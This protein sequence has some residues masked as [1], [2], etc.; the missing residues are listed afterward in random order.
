MKQ[1]TKT[2]IRYSATIFVVLSL[3]ALGVTLLLEAKFSLLSQ[4]LPME[5]AETMMIESAP[6]PERMMAQSLSADDTVATDSVAESR[7]AP[8]AFAPPTAALKEEESPTL[9]SRVA[10]L[11][12]GTLTVVVAGVIALLSAALGWL[13]SLPVRRAMRMQ[14]CFVADISHELKTPLSLMSSELALFR[15]RYAHSSPS[16]EAVDTLV[17][18]LASDTARL[19]RLTNRLLGTMTAR[20]GSGAAGAD[21]SFAIDDAHVF[22]DN[23]ITRYR[24]NCPTHHFTHKSEGLGSGVVWANGQDMIQVVE[25]LVENACTHTPEGSEV[26]ITEHSDDTQY[27]IEVSDNGP[28]IDEETQARIFNRLYRGPQGSHTK[29]YGLGLSIARELVRT[30]GGEIEVES[31]PGQG[32]TFTISLPSTAH[33]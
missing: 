19:S 12:L 4:S 15:E 24:A 20:E 27:Y 3:V 33:A 32:T 5:A 10:Q 1:S 31:T 6:A 8:T 11:S 30:S 7:M 29:G 13:F 17:D 26:V 2:I 28:G 25:I 16:D 18:N 9:S 22:L 14:Q 23:F 21:E